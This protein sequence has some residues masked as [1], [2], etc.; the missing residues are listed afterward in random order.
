MKF[1]KCCYIKKVV[2]ILLIIAIF[3]PQVSYASSTMKVNQRVNYTQSVIKKRN[4]IK[5]EKIVINADKLVANSTK[6]KIIED[7]TKYLQQ[8]I[9][10]I[11]KCGGGTV[12]IPKG[13]YYFASAGVQR[14]SVSECV[15][16]CKN[17]VTI[18]GAG[19]SGSLSTILKPYAPSNKLPV[20]MFYFNN[21]AE[22]GAKDKTYLENADFKNFI[23]DGINATSTTYTSAGKAFMINLLK[24]CDWENVIVKNT[25][26]TGIGVDCPINCTINNCVVINC[27]KGGYIFERNNYVEAPGASGIGIGTG[28]SNQESMYINNC[29]VE[30]NFKYGIF[31][32][33]QGRFSQDYTATDAKGF[34]VFNCTAKGNRYDFGGERAND[35]TYKN[36]ISKNDSV[37]ISS[38]HFGNMSRETNIVNCSVEKKFS[39]VTD[40]S[41][42]YYKP[43]YWA[44]NNSITEGTSKTTFSPNKEITRAEAVEFIWRMAGRPGKVMLN[45]ENPN[46]GFADVS[47]DNPY[48]DAIKWAREAGVISASNTFSPNDGCTRA[49]FVTMLW[50]YAGKPKVPNTNSFNDVAKG[51]Y[52]EDAVNWVVRRGIVNGKSA[53][54]FAP[55]DVA[56]RAEIITFLYRYNN[57]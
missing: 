4:D 29:I 42:Y 16:K 44:L 18:E 56:T 41:I 12:K 10:E 6:R 47:S 23:V 24:N 33:H 39:D 55:N 54:V 21:Y 25:D 13:T 34:V 31:F 52:Y 40:K 30:D 46:T 38:I 37:T 28:F 22:S 27:G 32:E 51:A 2:A 15:I 7:N 5:I 9:D 26:G 14:E 19:T 3:I 53:N 43:V 36:C 35:V 20:D 8:Y 17:N 11:S 49:Q 50:R 1:E 45:S 48:A 57:K